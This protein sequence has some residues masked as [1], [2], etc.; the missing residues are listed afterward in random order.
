MKKEGFDLQLNKRKITMFIVGCLITAISIMLFSHFYYIT[1]EFPVDKKMWIL[2]GTAIGS[3]WGF[4]FIFVSITSKIKSVKNLYIFYAVILVALFGCS[5]LFKPIRA[6][7]LLIAVDFLIYAI[8]GLLKNFVVTFLTLILYTYIGLILLAFST[9]GFVVPYW[10][11][12]IGLC[13]IFI[14][15]RYIGVPINRLLIKKWWSEGE[16]EKYNKEQMILQLKFLYLVFWI[17]VN[18]TGGIYD[19]ENMIMY[20]NI[21][22]IVVFIDVDF[23]KIIWLKR[24]NI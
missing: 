20:N 15:Y 3:F 19:S 21:F 1:G 6:M 24:N 2:S 22:L 4:V 10:I 8:I 9:N 11:A 5:A 7:I 23:K 18:I 13:A 16:S 12:Y 14:S 17:I